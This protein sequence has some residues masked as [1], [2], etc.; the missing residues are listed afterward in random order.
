[1]F[2]GQIVNQPRLTFPFTSWAMYGQPEHPE[3]LVFY[4]YEGLTKEQKRTIISPEE[5]LP[6]IG[7]SAVASKFRFLVRAAFSGRD[8]TE[9]EETL[10]ELRKFLTSIGGIYNRHHPENTIHSLEIIQ[11]SIDLS[12][13]GHSDIL[14]KSLLGVELKY[15]N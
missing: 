2:I 1:M 14:R 13:R 3:T 4:Q 10:E 12:K 9:R 15:R 11:C 5:L 6:T 8:D 7:D